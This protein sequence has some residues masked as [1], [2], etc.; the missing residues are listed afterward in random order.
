MIYQCIVGL[1]IRSIA[2]GM[3]LKAYR[4][5]HRSP[6][7]SAQ[8]LLHNSRNPPLERGSLLSIRIQRHTRRISG[9][10]GSFDLSLCWSSMCSHSDGRR[11]WMLVEAS[12]QEVI[13]ASALETC[14]PVEL[15][16]ARSPRTSSTD[17]VGSL[18][19]SKRREGVVEL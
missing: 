9:R 6:R 1:L 15:Q 2:S 19:M 11:T 10:S 17:E 3:R 16:P 18:A 13:Q 7:S 14:A 8:P 4:R 5:G 12:V